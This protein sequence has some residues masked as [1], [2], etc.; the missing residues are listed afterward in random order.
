MPSDLTVE[1]FDSFAR[2]QMRLFH[3]LGAIGH[4]TPDDQRRL[5]ALSESEWVAWVRFLRDGPLPPLPR[6]PEMLLRIAVA[7][8][9]VAELLDP[10]PLGAELV[11]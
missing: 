7:A 3:E 6:P 5:L 9:R 1:D 11:W 4:L 2:G 10:D 8:H